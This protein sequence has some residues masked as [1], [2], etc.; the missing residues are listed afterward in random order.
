MTTEPVDHTTAR[1]RAT[2]WWCLVPVAVLMAVVVVWWAVGLRHDTLA[3]GFGEAQVSFTFN[4]TDLHEALAVIRPGV[5]VR[6]ESA[7][8]GFLVTLKVTEMKERD[9]MHW[10]ASLIDQEITLTDGLIIVRE[11]SWL[12]RSHRA[13]AYWMRNTCGVPLWPHR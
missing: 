2:W 3:S 9:A 11:V 4:D 13:A 8:S 7:T 6:F 12:N 5:P 10:I 1:E